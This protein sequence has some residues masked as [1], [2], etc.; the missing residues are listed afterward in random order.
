M[1]AGYLYLLLLFA[2]PIADPPETIATAMSESVATS[3]RINPSNHWTFDKKTFA[4][5]IEP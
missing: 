5:L 4:I 2:G 3:K 1:I